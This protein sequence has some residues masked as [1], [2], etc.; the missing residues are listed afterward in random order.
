MV[1]NDHSLFFHQNQ[2]HKKAGNQGIEPGMAANYSLSCNAA[3]HTEQIRVSW[4]SPINLCHVS[5]LMK[6]RRK[7]SFSLFNL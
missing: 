4:V 3:D 5:D 1:L 7:T 2:W 6:N